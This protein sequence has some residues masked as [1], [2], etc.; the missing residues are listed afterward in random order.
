MRIS[1]DIPDEQIKDLTLICKIKKVSRAELIR[2][3]ISEYIKQNKPSIN[4]AF[5]IWKKQKIDISQENGKRPTYNLK[6]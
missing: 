1:V 5:G 4:D 2:Q 3:A 6:D